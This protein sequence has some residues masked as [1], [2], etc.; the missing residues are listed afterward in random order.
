MPT[1]EEQ[2]ETIGARS[3]SELS[4]MTPVPYKTLN[5]WKVTRPEWFQMVVDYAA[6]KMDIRRW[7]TIHWKCSECGNSE[8][9]DV[10]INKH[11]IEK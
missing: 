11:G 8:S 2:L 3:V 5:A 4:R 9:A 6:A 10:R 7:V 1:L